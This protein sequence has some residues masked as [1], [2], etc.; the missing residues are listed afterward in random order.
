MMVNKF[1]FVPVLI[2]DFM[3]NLIEVK[4]K[5]LSLKIEN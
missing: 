5:C 4:I 2:E 1:F 3:A